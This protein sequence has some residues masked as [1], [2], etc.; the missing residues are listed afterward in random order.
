[1]YTR[2]MTTSSTNSDSFRCLAPRQA[3]YPLLS[4]VDI[5]CRGKLVD[6]Q[7]TRVPEKSSSTKCQVYTSVLVCTIFSQ[8][9]GHKRTQLRQR[10]SQSQAVRIITPSAQSSVISSAL[11]NS[12]LRVSLG[13]SANVTLGICRARY[14]ARRQLFVPLSISVRCLAPT[15][16]SRQVCRRVSMIVPVRR[17]CPAEPCCLRPVPTH[18]DHQW[19]YRAIQT[20]CNN[21]P[22]VS[23]RTSTSASPSA[24]TVASTVP[25]YRYCL[26]TI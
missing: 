13:A 12:M 22:N 18:K 10:L 24:R 19:C 4:C 15:L 23:S 8:V 25:S 3:Q 20:K 2:S 14:K 21:M 26:V 17:Q 16:V 1:M 7:N 5:Q 11:P 6:A 9:L